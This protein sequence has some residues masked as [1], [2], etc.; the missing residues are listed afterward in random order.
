MDSLEYQLDEPE[1]ETKNIHDYSKKS[2]IIIA[3]L[4]ITVVLFLAGLIVI[5]I[6]Y[7]KEK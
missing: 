2:K 3:I 1:T 4:I 5:I 6:L 7:L